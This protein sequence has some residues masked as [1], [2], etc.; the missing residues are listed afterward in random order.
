MGEKVTPPDSERLEY[1][2]LGAASMALE[3]DSPIRLL[4]HA[5]RWVPVIVRWARPLSL[6]LPV[7]STST[8]ARLEQSMFETLQG[9]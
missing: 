6:A 3:H 2:A 4:A 9:C 7:L 5:E 8:T 1:G